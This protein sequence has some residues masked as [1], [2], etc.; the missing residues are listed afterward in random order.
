MIKSKETI[1]KY[2]PPTL[3]ENGI[4]EKF[5]QLNNVYA[6]VM[7]GTETDAEYYGNIQDL[8]HNAGIYLDAT[9]RLFNVYRFPE[10]NDDNYRE[11]IKQSVSNR[12]YSCS[13]VDQNNLL[14][15]YF[16][17]SGMT[18]EENPNNEPATIRIN[19]SAST[20]DMV[21]S[22]RLINNIRAGGVKFLQ[23]ISEGQDFQSHQKYFGALITSSYRDFEF[24][25]YNWENLKTNTWDTV[26]LYTWNEIKDGGLI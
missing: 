5:K 18:M 12:L 17:N 9:G 21:N 11:R 13:L 7:E 22:V 23:N 2:T 25:F 20:R 26:K 19:G 16:P 24:D 8:E 10:E 15:K 1:L 14:K 3:K 4:A 6:E